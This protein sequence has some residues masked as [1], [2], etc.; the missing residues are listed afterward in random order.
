MDGEAGFEPALT[1][2]RGA[3]LTILATFQ[4]KNGLVGVCGESNTRFSDPRSDAFPLGYTPIYKI[5][6]SGRE[7]NSRLRFWRP[8][9]YR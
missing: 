9:S 1:R 2:S 5:W 8:P 7:L 3:R 6:H 4:Q